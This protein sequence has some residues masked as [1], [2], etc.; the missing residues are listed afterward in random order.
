MTDGI[1]YSLITPAGWTHLPVAAATEE[2]VGALV[3][4]LAAREAQP[5]PRIST[6]RRT[7]LLSALEGASSSGA[8]D[9]YFPTDLV[10]GVIA[11]LSLVVSVSPRPP[12][13]R[14]TSDVLLA[15]AAKHAG[16]EATSV[17]SRLAVRYVEELPAQHDA[18]GEITVPPSRRVSLLIDSPDPAGRF[19][20]VTGTIL[21]I[22]TTDDAA[23][24]DALE[25]LLDSIVNTMGFESEKVRP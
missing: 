23:V 8:Q 10:G 25:F 9:L 16:S 14:S 15:F 11:P 19:L 13:G 17:D 7:M 21:R 2:N 24:M 5:D 12:Q 4:N 18:N 3:D 20:L 1:A 22:A 6:L